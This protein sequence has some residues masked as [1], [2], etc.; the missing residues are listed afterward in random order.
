MARD[1][2][3]TVNFDKLSAAER[4]DWQ[5]RAIG[6]CQT[7]REARQKE[8]IEHEKAAAKA[9]EQAKQAREQAAFEQQ[10]RA[11]AARQEQ[12]VRQAQQEAQFAANA[13]EYVAQVN[14]LHTRAIDAGCE[15]VSAKSFALDAKDLVAS[16]KK[17]AVFRFYQ[18]SGEEQR[19]AGLPL[20]TEDA[21]RDFRAYL[22]DITSDIFPR[23]MVLLG[24]AEKCTEQ[25]WNGV[26]RPLI[27]LH[28]DD[29]W[30]LPGY[31]TLPL[32]GDALATI[33][34]NLPPEWQE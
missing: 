33:A 4:H 19:L 8:I 9:A 29:G 13:R 7:A 6:F 3:I 17:I 2:K 23:Q 26:E 24:Q 31:Q 32:G 22:M 16:G 30:H 20:I 25:M 21:T 27:C 5:A 18:K 12:A 11:Q 15:P 10:A 34:K 14:A 28:V 1:H